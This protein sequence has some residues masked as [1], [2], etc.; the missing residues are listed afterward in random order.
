MKTV[1]LIGGTGWPATRDYYSLLNQLTQARL[2]RL[3]GL[4][5]R[6]W[7]FDFQAL[8]DSGEAAPD[9]MHAAFGEAA[10][11]LQRAGAQVLA[12]ASNTGHL[13]LR[14]VLS[15]LQQGPSLVHIAVACAQAMARAGVQRAGVLATRRALDGGVFDDAFGRAGIAL[16]PPAADVA[17]AVDNAIFSELEHGRAGPK[18]TAALTAACHAWS[19]QGVTQVLL[20]CTEIRPALFAGTPAA[21]GLILWDSTLLHCAAIVDAALAG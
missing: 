15:P 10:L 13:F 1:G 17:A 5:L 6:V 12:L 16:L 21:D 18:T 19:G 7:S 20:G 4:A 3:H 11:G 14:D 9:A 8:L 2:G